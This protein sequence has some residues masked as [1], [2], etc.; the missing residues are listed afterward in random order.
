MT[1]PEALELLKLPATIRRETLTIEVSTKFE[2]GRSTRA[3][4]LRA[5]DEFIAESARYLTTVYLYEQP[6]MK[7]F[8]RVL[9]D[10]S[11]YHDIPLTRKEADTIVGKRQVTIEMRYVDNATG[12]MHRR[13]AEIW[14]GE[15]VPH[16][17][18]GD[19]LA[20][21]KQTAEPIK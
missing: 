13:V 8:H 5:M 10:D 15:P 12:H 18:I 20:Y 7:W 1:I 16:L 6:G 2:D 19:T 11:S 21:D 14:P 3:A 9:V 4:E 17:W